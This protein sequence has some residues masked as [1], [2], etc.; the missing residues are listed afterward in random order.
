MVV[1]VMVRRW[2]LALGMGADEFKGHSPT[3]MMGLAR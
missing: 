2:T 1:T 3:A